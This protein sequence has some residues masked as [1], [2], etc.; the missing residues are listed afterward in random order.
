MLT[1]TL[2]VAWLAASFGTSCTQPAPQVNMS[3][4]L[5]ALWLE[6]QPVCQMSCISPALVLL[7]TCESCAAAGH[8]GT[9]GCLLYVGTTRGGRRENHL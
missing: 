7:L 4:V 5:Q 2:L 3:T 6:L 8:S 9:P 1:R